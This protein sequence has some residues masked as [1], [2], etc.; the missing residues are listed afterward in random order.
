MEVHSVA[1]FMSKPW[2]WISEVLFDV[3]EQP[4]SDDAWQDDSS[5]L[6]SARGHAHSD[7]HS[8][9]LK[10]DLESAAL[11]DACISLDQTKALLRTSTPW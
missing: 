8:T 7:F 10:R 11:E 6:E 5:L 3:P 4:S 1:T 2:L 9:A